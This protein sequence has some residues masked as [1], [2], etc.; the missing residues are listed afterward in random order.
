MHKT[1]SRQYCTV[2]E[3]ANTPC[4]NRDPVATEIKVRFAETDAQGIAHNAAYL[5]WFEVARVDY[6]ATH[7]GGYPALRARGIEALTIESHVRYLVP[8]HFDDRLRVRTACRDVRGA[9]F[10]FEYVIERD[11]EAVAD[12]WTAHA[13][14]HAETFRPTRMPTWLA[15]AIATAER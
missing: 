7:A 1:L 15:E 14:V 3:S 12:G 9:R 8:V 5:V 11:G 13:C 10:R 4:P 2:Q 6:L